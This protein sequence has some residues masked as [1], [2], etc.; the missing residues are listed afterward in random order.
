MLVID[1]RGLACPQPVL[2]AR[3]GMT[4]SDKLSVSVSDQSQV[5]NIQR[6]AERSGWTVTSVSKDGYFEMTLVKGTLDQ[7]ILVKPEDLV[8]SVDSN[9]TQS[10]K[11][12]VINSD[13]MG[14]G[15][16]ELGGLLVRSFLSTLKDV[17]P[18]PKTL[19]LYNSGVKLAVAGS[20]ALDTLKELEKSGIELLVCGTCLGYFEIKDTLQAGTV[21]NMFDIASA[22]LSASLTVVI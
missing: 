16:D 17:D 7:E 18:K 20:K 15:S 4:E 13:T 21:S 8:C 9:V 19:I 10:A 5:E 14:N 1:A 2:K 22:M 11:V 3:K 12:V 6:M